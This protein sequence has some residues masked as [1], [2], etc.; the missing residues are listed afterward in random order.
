MSE[1]DSGGGSSKKL[2]I[3]QRKSSTSGNFSLM[4][5]A[6]VEG[7]DGTIEVELFAPLAPKIFSVPSIA[8]EVVGVGGSL[9]DAEA[10]SI[11]RGDGGEEG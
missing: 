3:D 11:S 10:F 9:L 1:P 5:G 7:K 2:L 4:Q 6:M 8:V